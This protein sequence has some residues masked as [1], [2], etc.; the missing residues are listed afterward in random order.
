MLLRYTLRIF[1]LQLLKPEK[2]IK[3]KSSKM[4]GASIDDFT[5]QGL[6]NCALTPPISSQNFQPVLRNSVDLI[7]ATYGE[8]LSYVVPEVNNYFI[9]SFI[10]LYIYII[11]MFFYCNFFELKLIVLIIKYIEKKQII[12]MYNLK[13]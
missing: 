13:I 12:F 4:F 8:L 6:G 7:N 11:L 5:W 9:L 1:M 3:T 2:N 10:C